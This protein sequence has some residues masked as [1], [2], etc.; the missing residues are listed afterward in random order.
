MGFYRGSLPYAASIPRF[1]SVPPTV[2]A[3]KYGVNRPSVCLE[4]SLGV[5]ITGQGIDLKP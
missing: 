3:Q 5:P 2:M 4:L 1:R